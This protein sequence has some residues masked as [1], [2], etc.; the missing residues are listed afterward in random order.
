MTSTGGDRYANVVPATY[1]G[2]RFRSLTETRWAVL[3]TALG[4]DF[5]YEPETY[6]LGPVGWYLPDFWVSKLGDS[7]CFLEVKASGR[8]S[9]TE[10]DRAKALHLLTR[11]PVVVAQGFGLPPW[12]RFRAWLESDYRPWTIEWPG[13]LVDIFAP[14]DPD[15]RSAGAGGP[16]HHLAT[17]TC[18]TV[19][20]SVLGMGTKCPGLVAD[21]HRWTTARL[22]A[23]Y[24]EALAYRPDRR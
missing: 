24:H 4:L 17:C 3:L 11:Q 18:G 22:D 21:G 14:R 20:V 8:M 1:L 16:S 12:A 10:F 7:G 2:R 15:L 13:E 23:A 5:E 9:D 6:D 19:G